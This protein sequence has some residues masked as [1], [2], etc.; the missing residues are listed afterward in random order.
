MNSHN[1]DI[2]N[3]SDPTYSSNCAVLFNSEGYSMYDVLYYIPIG[4]VDNELL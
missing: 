1:F 2:N 3:I 4:I